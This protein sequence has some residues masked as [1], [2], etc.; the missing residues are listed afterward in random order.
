VSDEKKKSVAE[1]VNGLPEPSV[2]EEELS[3]IAKEAHALR[4][5]LAISRATYGKSRQ[6]SKPKPLS[7][8]EY[9]YPKT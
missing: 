4:K 7:L 5:L 3:R 1:F 9:P 2:I 8:T 6:D